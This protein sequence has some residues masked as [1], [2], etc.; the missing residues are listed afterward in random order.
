MTVTFIAPGALAGV[1]A[2]I[3]VLLTTVTLVAAAVPMATVAPLT[4]FVPVMVT[5]VPP[6]VVPDVGE[7]LVTVG[8]WANADTHS[9]Q[10]KQRP[11][12]R[13]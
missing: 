7:M 9:A 1:I 11:G 4:K 13:P 3:V 12:L 6:A 2:V 10:S 8:V 5:G